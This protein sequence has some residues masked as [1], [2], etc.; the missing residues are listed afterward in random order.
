MRLYAKWFWGFRPEIAP[1]ITFRQEGSRR[2]LLQNRKTEDRIVFVVSNSDGANPSDRE[3]ILGMAEIGHI[4]VDSEDAIPDLDALPDD[5]FQNGKYKWPKAIFMK[6]AWRFDPPIDD[7]REVMTKENW[8]NYLQTAQDNAVLLN[9]EEQEK[10]LSYPHKE[11]PLNLNESIA[12]AAK[13]RS[14]LDQAIENL[15]SDDDWRAF[16]SRTTNAIMGRVK[17]N[18]GQTIERVVKNKTTDMSEG[19]MQVEL[20]KLIDEQQKR[21]AIT[22]RE[23]VL[24]DKW[25]QPS[26]DR[27]DSSKGYV[28]GNLQITTWAANMAKSDLAPSE[29]EDYFKALQSSGK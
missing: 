28:K 18:N 22:G 25:L 26:I 16:V 8:Y 9:E 14:E 29:V 6:R 1:I 23:F 7:W 21:C 19:L 17:Y 27:I 3:K 20:Q 15:H 13:S 12:Q 4:E 2:R 10:I 5:H 11:I 24:N